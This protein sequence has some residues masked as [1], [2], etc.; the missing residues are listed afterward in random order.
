MEPIE[1]AKPPMTPI[2][3]TLEGNLRSGGR[4]YTI[5]YGDVPAKDIAIARAAVVKEMIETMHIELSKTTFLKVDQNKITYFDES[6]SHDLSI[7]ETM[8]G[9]LSQITDIAQGVLPKVVFNIKPYSDSSELSRSTLSDSTLSLSTSSHELSKSA[10][11]SSQLSSSK[12]SES[13][14]PTTTSKGWLSYFWGTKEASEPEKNAAQVSGQFKTL[15]GSRLA[16]QMN[17]LTKLANLLS[18]EEKTYLDFKLFVEACTAS[19]AKST[20]DSIPAEAE[21]AYIR[22]ISHAEIRADKNLS[23]ALYTLYYSHFRHP[24][25]LK[26]YNL[27][28]FALRDPART[29]IPTVPI[30]NTEFT[31]D[32][33]WNVL[34]GEPYHQ[35][36]QMIRHGECVIRLSIPNKRMCEV[37][38]PLDLRLFEPLDQKKCRLIFEA[39]NNYCNS[40]PPVLKVVDLT[41]L[42]TPTQI[43]Q[44]EEVARNFREE[45]VNQIHRGLISLCDS[46]ISDPKLFVINLTGK[47][48]DIRPIIFGIDNLVSK[49]NVISSKELNTALY[50]REVHHAFQEYLKA[51]E[52]VKAAPDF[53]TAKQLVE[54]AKKVRQILIDA[55][56]S[57][58]IPLVNQLFADVYPVDAVIHFLET[59]IKDVD[60][61]TLTD[62]RETLNTDPVIFYNCVRFVHAVA[63]AEAR[64]ETGILNH[65]TL[66]IRDALDIVSQY[67]SLAGQFINSRTLALLRLST[68]AY[69]QR[70]R[71]YDPSAHQQFDNELSRAAARRIYSDMASIDTFNDQNRNARLRIEDL[72]RAIEPRPQNE[73]RIIPPA[74]RKAPESFLSSVIAMAG[75][76]NPMGLLYSKEMETK[77]EITLDDIEEMYEAARLEYLE[78]HPEAPFQALEAP[79]AE[80]SS[81]AHILQ[82]SEPLPPPTQPPEIKTEQIMKFLT[83][84]KKELLASVSRGTVT[85]LD[86]PLLTDSLGLEARCIEIRDEIQSF[87]VGLKTYQNF[88]QELKLAGIITPAEQNQYLFKLAET[89]SQLERIH[90]RMEGKEG[91][92]L[93][94]A[95]VEAFS[96]FMLRTLALNLHEVNSRNFKLIE[97]VVELAGNPKLRGMMDKLMATG[98]HHLIDGNFTELS[99]LAELLSKPETHA[100][101]TI[102][103]LRNAYDL[104]LR[105]HDFLQ[106]VG[107]HNHLITRD[108]YN[109]YSAK[110]DILLNLL[111]KWIRYGE[112]STDP[113]LTKGLVF[114]T[115]SANKKVHVEQ[116]KAVGL[117]DQIASKFSEIKSL[118][119]LLAN[120]QLHEKLRTTDLVKAHS[121]LVQYRDF[122]NGAKRSHFISEATSVTYSANLNNLIEVLEKWIAVAKDK[123]GVELINEFLPRTSGNM[124]EGTIALAKL[125]G[126]VLTHINNFKLSEISTTTHFQEEA[127]PIVQLV[128]DISMSM[129][130]FRMKEIATGN[131]LELERILKKFHSP[132]PLFMFLPLRFFPRIVEHLN[133]LDRDAHAPERQPL[134]RMYAD[135][136]ESEAEAAKVLN[137]LDE[138]TLRAA[139]LATQSKAAK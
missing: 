126:T 131:T 118:Q 26:D 16:V 107:I 137:A 73:S 36:E 40:T 9:R 63:D 108:T 129:V 105:Y 89:I 60:R 18:K 33:R 17:D 77:P 3:I 78:E 55:N 57:Q 4:I 69:E 123:E 92:A 101:L 127:T 104:I 85:D 56:K 81:A 43:K 120:P 22:L 12:L 119:D 76:I 49:R 103:H 98:L 21:A 51:L 106:H 5:N 96:P 71:F 58:L 59:K 116:L 31:S 54:A 67:N 1:S 34:Q 99:D 124:N 139:T 25:T 39:L 52:K 62:L 117:Y 47:I 45:A 37:R 94:K 28:Q 70:L 61:S 88:L 84:L 2:E 114:I 79:N 44:L 11:S 13:L 6:G 80:P 97:K 109:R 27:F 32:V 93:L 82:E 95:T 74:P 38:I 10:L 19:K 121:Q 138:L 100:K 75:Y 65:S 64:L 14:T 42:L 135:V 72:D 8:K 134:L 86:I 53:E 125:L 30:K 110:L 113:N 46:S 68:H 87:V 41:P 128:K 133:T 111:E 122:L 20:P 91:A 35:G 50:M 48:R 112:S 15:L 90:A 136:L 23:G 83:A 130:N 115:Q 66:S 29:G 102:T 132:T 7:P 24:E